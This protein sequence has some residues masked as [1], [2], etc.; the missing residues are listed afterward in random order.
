MFKKGIAVTAIFMASTFVQ[1]LSQIIITRIFGA[2]LTL[3]T[4]LAAVALPSIIV[5]V[6]YGTFNDAFLPLLGEK[7]AQDPEQ[8]DQ[9]FFSH[10]LTLL[11]VS[12]GVGA[13]MMSASGPLSAFMYGGRGE[14]FVK[15]VAYQ[16]R[17]LFMSI[18]LAVTATLLGTYLYAQKKFTRF[19]LAQL[20]GSLLNLGIVFLL[21]ESM[22][23]WALVIGFTLAILVQIIMVF[24]RSL[25]GSSFQFANMGPF[26][27]ALTPL[28]IGSFALRSDTLII[29]AY[30]S[31]MPEGSLVYLNLISKIFS[32][33]T[34]V[35]TIGI[36]VL[37]LPHLVE[38]IAQKEYEKT[39]QYVNKAKILG[40]FITI[41]VIISITLFAPFIIKLLFVGGKFTLE[42]A[43]NTSSMIPYFILPALAWGTSSIFFQPLIALK[44]QLQLG[45]LNVAALVLALLAAW[46]TNEMTNPFAAIIVGITVLLLTGIIGSEILWQYYKK[47]LLK[48]ENHDIKEI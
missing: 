32:I 20:V 7:K 42:D 25:L 13:L 37:L 26:F 31:L 2:D 30:G 11:L 1:L 3:D 41:G 23:I 19:P 22:G 34:G 6:I 9:F 38:Y 10:F 47:R 21:A 29:R 27:L 24:P 4:F 8:T 12:F 35:I 45:M 28:I 39:I 36:Q 15:E 14:E 44:K 33:A 43:E 16:M 17:F 40:L 18:P 46:I 48:S 5:T